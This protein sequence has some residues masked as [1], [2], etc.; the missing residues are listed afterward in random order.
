ML[1]PRNTWAK[2]EN[3]RVQGSSG[4][5]SAHANSELVSQIENTRQFYL[6]NFPPRTTKCSISAPFGS[7]FINRGMVAELLRRDVHDRVV[8]TLDGRWI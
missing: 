7:H 8:G 4:P 5:T 6:L 1:F 3:R 2:I